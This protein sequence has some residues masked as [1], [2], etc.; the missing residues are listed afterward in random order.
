MTCLT[1]SLDSSQEWAIAEC[2]ILKVSQVVTLGIRDRPYADRPSSDRVESASENRTTNADGQPG[3]RL[4]PH[5]PEPSY[6]HHRAAGMRRCFAD[7]LDK[8]ILN[9]TKDMV[10]KHHHSLST[11]GDVM[12]G[13]ILIG[14]ERLREP[15]QKITNFIKQHAGIAIGGQVERRQA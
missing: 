9:I 6:D 13:Y 10:Q 4:P 2:V 8:L 7:W 5:A 3:H 1:L 14:V 12:A 15:M 11:A